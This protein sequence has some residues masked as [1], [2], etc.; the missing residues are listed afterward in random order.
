MQLSD[1]DFNLPKELIANK[2]VT[3]RDSSRLL[4]VQDT[5]QD[6]KFSDVLDYLKEGDVLVVNNTKVISALLRAKN[7]SVH[8][9]LNNRVS[10]D[11]WSTFVKGAKKIKVGDTLIFSESLNGTVLEKREFGEAIIKFNL[12]DEAFFNELE[13]VGEIPLPPYIK[14]DDTI[15][16]RSS[17][18]T[19][20]AKTD[21]A[22]AAPTA[23][24]HFTPEL[25]KKIA[26]L[27][28]KIAHVTLHVGAGTFL[29]IK[30]ENIADHK[31]HS[32]YI[33]LDKEN[34]NTIKSAK[35]VVAVGTTSLRTLEGIYQKLGRLDEF[36]GE[37]NIFI[38]PGFK[39]KVVDVLITN[40]HLPKTSLLLLV[41]AFSG[42]DKIR[43]AY[44]H[45][46]EQKYRFFSYGDACL[47]FCNSLLHR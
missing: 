5:I 35:R 28:V 11:T 7:K 42:V 15:D 25:L 44:L 29:P 37:T 21:G 4:V 1:F 9:N 6:K 10:N 22:V 14:K 8:L 26:D 34:L 17:Y 33:N 46:I 18:Q 47:L 27:G 3:P 31:M 2:P 20:Y 40:F 13:K 30:H 36:S 41:S 38:T 32:E 43:A 16:N 39:F 19:V 24:F 12:S 45:A 23:G